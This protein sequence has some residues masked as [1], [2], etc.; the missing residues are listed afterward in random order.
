MFVCVVG[1]M[2]YHQALQ[3]EQPNKLWLSALENSWVVALFRDE[4]IYIHAYIQGFFDTIKGYGKRISEIKDTY[5][6]AIQKAYVI[7]VR[8]FYCRFY[9]FSE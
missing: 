2:L 7:L 6:H 9:G 5:N 4:V 3:Q 1:F 8:Y